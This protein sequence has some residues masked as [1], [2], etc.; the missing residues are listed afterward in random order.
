ME[1][2]LEG[3]HRLGIRLETESPGGYF[4]T[5]QVE[6]DEGPAVGVRTEQGKDF[7]II[8]EATSTRPGD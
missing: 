5:P 2:E 8:L 3:R 6:D 1:E 7:R 4:G